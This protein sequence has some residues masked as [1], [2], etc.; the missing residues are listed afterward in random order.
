M[1]EQKYCFPFISILYFIPQ[2]TE[3]FGHSHRFT[4]QKNFFL[5]DIQKQEYFSFL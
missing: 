2:Q 1:H 4:F 5:I 3:S